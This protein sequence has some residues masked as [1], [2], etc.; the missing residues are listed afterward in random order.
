MKKFNLA[1]LV[2]ILSCV[3]FSYVRALA[4][5]TNSDAASSRANLMGVIKGPSGNTLEGVPVSAR[6]QG[7]SI[8]TTVYTDDSGMYLF[9]AF[10]PG[11]YSVSAQAIGFELTR[12]DVD[13][14]SKKEAR[15][16]LTLKTVDDFTKQL[17]APEWM[18]ALPEDTPENRRG[19]SL[20]RNN[21]T[22][23][24]PANWV[25][26]NRFDEAGWTRIIDYME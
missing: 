23:C 25:L 11:H 8:R 24:H 20:L 21:C 14:E 5:Q 15:V 6:A 1:I 16:D 3:G 18:A 22:G 13:L 7:E 2:L 17:S 9:P 4:Q 10:H 19:K 12:R 26:Q